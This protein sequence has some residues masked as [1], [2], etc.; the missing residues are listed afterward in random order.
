MG[1]PLNLHF[2]P[3]GPAQFALLMS[4]VSVSRGDP[5]MAVSPKPDRHEFRFCP[6]GVDLPFPK[7]LVSPSWQVFM[8]I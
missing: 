5:H 3:T 1:G 2:E 8:R 6:V 7:C 4:F